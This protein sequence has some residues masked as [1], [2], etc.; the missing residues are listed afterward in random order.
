[1]ALARLNDPTTGTT[2]TG[3]N[4]GTTPK[5]ITDFDPNKPK[6]PTN[7]TGNQYYGLQFNEDGVPYVPST[8]TGAEDP[9]G[10]NSGRLPASQMQDV[11]PSGFTPQTDIYAN[12]PYAKANNLTP[13]QMVAYENSLISQG[14]SREYARYILGNMNPEDAYKAIMA[15][16]N[17]KIS[18]TEN[19]QG[20]PSGGGG[21]GGQNYSYTPPVMYPFSSTGSTYNY[22]APDYSDYLSKMKDLLEEEKRAR[23]EA[24][25]SQYRA[26]IGKADRNYEDT[27]NQIE[28]NN[29][30]T[31]RWLDENYGGYTTG[32]GLTN[33]LRAN[34]NLENN[35]AD[36]LKNRS[37]A[38]Q[39]AETQ[40]QSSLADAVKSYNSQYSNLAQNMYGTQFSNELKRYQMNLED[41]QQR[42]QQELDYQYRLY[43]KQLGL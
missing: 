16:R 25:E 40:R 14:V 26:L 42:R 11:L 39:N 34:T 23:N 17:Q 12:S 4:G 36:A 7:T 20:T 33:R 5:P 9:P 35:L 32:Q 6:T 24:T 37:E 41:E 21:G 18:G 2:T 15:I 10:S 29:V 31:Q 28:R 13:E 19:P 43:L 27:R 8:I 1:M 3:T 22:E 30:R 38:Y